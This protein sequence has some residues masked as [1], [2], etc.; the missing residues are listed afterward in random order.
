M[1]KSCRV[2]GD[3]TGV[4]FMAALTLM[5]MKEAGDDPR[6][7]IALQKTI[8][9]RSAP[10]L[11]RLLYLARSQNNRITLFASIKGL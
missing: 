8:R 6:I 10:L 3:D 7:M 11:L 4:G 2:A 9:Y 1:G 5:Q